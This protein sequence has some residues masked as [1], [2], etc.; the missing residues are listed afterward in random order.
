MLNVQT[1]VRVDV[2]LP[3]PPLISDPYDRDV[4]APESLFAYPEQLG[5]SLCC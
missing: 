2:L 1:Y 5:D 3:V 4:Q